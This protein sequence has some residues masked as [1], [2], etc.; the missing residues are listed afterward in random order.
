[1]TN[2]KIYKDAKL[3]NVFENIDMKLYLADGE[4]RYDFIVHPQADPDKIQ[5]KIVGSE[6]YE[7]KK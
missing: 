3:L 1:M 2:A 6:G 7:I 5:F 4:L